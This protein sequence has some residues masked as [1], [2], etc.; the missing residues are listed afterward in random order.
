MESLGTMPS[1]TPEE[2]NSELTQ[3]CERVLTGAMDPAMKALTVTLPSE[4]YLADR[5][6]QKGLVDVAANHARRQ[7][8]K[9]LLGS[10]LVDHWQQ[11]SSQY[12]LHGAYRASAA[13][14]GVRALQ[15]VAQDFLLAAGEGDLSVIRALHEQADNLKGR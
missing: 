13:D 6:A 12:R 15:H 3:A 1:E 14:I 2:I 7:K 9:A 10:R 4:E 11:V 5:A 8:M